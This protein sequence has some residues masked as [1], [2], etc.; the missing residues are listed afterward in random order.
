MPLPPLAG[1]HG[2]ADDR[3]AHLDDDGHDTLLV[4]VCAMEMADECARP[5]WLIAR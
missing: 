4:F 5:A 3:Q 2:R 1:I